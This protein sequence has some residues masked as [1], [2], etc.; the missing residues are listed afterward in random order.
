MAKTT[1]EET[2]VMEQEEFF[3]DELSLE[4]KK[5]LPLWK[6]IAIG[7]ATGAAVGAGLSIVVLCIINKG[8]SEEILVLKDEL[9]AAKEA[10]SAA[11]AVQD[12]VE[13]ATEAAEVVEEVI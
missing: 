7:S 4:T 3:D 9:S 2:K 10:L 6:K 8:L 12:T 11:K 13:V 1:K 5:K